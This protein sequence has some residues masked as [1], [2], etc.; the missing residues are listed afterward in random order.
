MTLMPLLKNSPCCSPRR[1]ILRD[2]RIKQG[3]KAF[4]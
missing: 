4:G 2:I 1:A 3:T